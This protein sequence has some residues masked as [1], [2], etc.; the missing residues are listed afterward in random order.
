MQNERKCENFHL[1]ERH[2]VTKVESRYHGT[3]FHYCDRCARSYAEQFQPSAILTSAQRYEAASKSEDAPQTELAVEPDVAG[4]DWVL[5]W[6]SH[7]DW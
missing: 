2:A 6:N 1:C 5:V 4:D 7:E 3:V